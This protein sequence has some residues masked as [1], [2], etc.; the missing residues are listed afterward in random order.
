MEFFL[1]NLEAFV[2]AIALFVSITGAGISRWLSKKDME[3]ERSQN[4]NKEKFFSF[5]NLVFDFLELSSPEFI[6]DIFDDVFDVNLQE[7][8]SDHNLMFVVDKTYANIGKRKTQIS[9]SMVK[10]RISMP[11][12]VV[13]TPELLDE[14]EDLKKELLSVFSVFEEELRKAYDNNSN[15]IAD[16]NKLVN[17]SNSYQM[18]YESKMSTIENLLLKYQKQLLR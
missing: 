7:V 3:K 4:L 12:D 2:S 13:K 17:L 1:D 18:M 9:I 11:D 16:Q 6:D 15:T 14:F 8:E 5:S 10:M